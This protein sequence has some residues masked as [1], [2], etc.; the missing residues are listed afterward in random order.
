MRILKGLRNMA[1]VTGYS[2]S[3]INVLKARK[4]N[5]DIKNTLMLVNLK[6]GKMDKTSE[7]YVQRIA[8]FDRVMIEL[9]RAKWATSQA[10]QSDYKADW[11]HSTQL[12]KSAA[13]MADALHDLVQSASHDPLDYDPIELDSLGTE[14]Q[15][16]DGA[17]LVPSINPIVVLQGSDYDMGYQYATQLIEIFGTW[18]LSRNAGNDYDAN[19]RATMRQW[20]LQIQT[21]APEF[22][23]FFQGWAAGATASG[24][25]M[26]YDDVSHGF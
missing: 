26:S 11:K 4:A 20:E 16:A 1:S 22:I 5:Q 13:F 10:M 17:P 24:V 15:F 25:V 9:T 3:N 21:H 23:S 19:Q 18:V 14:I 8:E 7:M 2:L 6:L 12:Y